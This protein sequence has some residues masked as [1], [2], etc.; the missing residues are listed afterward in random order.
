M[1]MLETSRNVDALSESVPLS[2][3][4]SSLSI[5]IMILDDFWVAG[6]LLSSVLSAER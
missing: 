2:R 4:R 5:T 6:M 1:D 3:M